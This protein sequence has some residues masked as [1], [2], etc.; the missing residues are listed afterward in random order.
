MSVGDDKKNTKVE[1]EMKRKQEK[2]EV[3]YLSL[4]R[5]LLSFLSASEDA[6]DQEAYVGDPPAYIINPSLFFLYSSL[7]IHNSSHLPREYQ[8][9]SQ[10]LYSFVCGV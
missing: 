10:L 9:S 2:K 3:S 6:D 4:G 5:L 1:G 7:Y 8:T